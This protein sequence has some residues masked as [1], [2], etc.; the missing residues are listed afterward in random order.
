[1]TLCIGRGAVAQ[2]NG[3]G[4]S[5][6]S[7]PIEIEAGVDIA[8][9]HIGDLITY[10]LTITYDTSIQL[11][12]PPI[13]VNMGAFDVKNYAIGEPEEIDGGRRR[14]VM[15]VLQKVPGDAFDKTHLK[16][17]IWMTPGQE[18][19]RSFKV[20]GGRISTADLTGPGLGYSGAP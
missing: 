2:D 6:W 12:P 5:S 4:N 20:A 17:R 3:A 16:Q 10:T 13:G 18:A 14:L 8:E 1:M 7:S 9:A 15:H 19:V 11:F